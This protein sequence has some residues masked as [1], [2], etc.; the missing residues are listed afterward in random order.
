M[1]YSLGDNTDLAG[2]YWH[3]NVGL[4]EAIPRF[5]IQLL[6]ITAKWE[7]TKSRRGLKLAYCLFTNSPAFQSMSLPLAVFSS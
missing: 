5:N 4:W 2:N 3:R 6:P 7:T 1:S